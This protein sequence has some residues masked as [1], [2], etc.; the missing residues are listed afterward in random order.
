MSS[1]YLKSSIGISV[2][3]P[4]ITCIGIGDGKKL[5]KRIS[6]GKSFAI[7]ISLPPL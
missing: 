5:E 1:I 4:L 3:T 2:G 7:G 6:I